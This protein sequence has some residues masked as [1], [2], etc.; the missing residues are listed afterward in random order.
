MKSV[1]ILLLFIL[2]LHASMFGYSFSDNTNE[3]VGHK[4][5]Y[6]VFSAS[7]SDI[8]SIIKHGDYAK[9][10]S[11]NNNIISVEKRVEDA[12]MSTK[13]RKKLQDNIKKYRVI[14]QSCIKA[15]ETNAP[16]LDKHYKTLI[17]SLNDF[18]RG[19]NS[20]GF[21]PLIKEWHKLSHI[22]K[23]YIK[24]PSNKLEKEFEETLNLVVLTVSEL[25]L[26]EELEE[27]LLSYLKNYQAYFNDLSRSYKSVKYENINHIKP[28]SYQ[29]K[30]QIKLSI[31]YNL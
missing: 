20:T 6:E 24:E 31:P 19:I 12:E 22:K 3:N 25:Y 21:T 8:N 29:I 13:E 11:F 15:M 14:C 27:P 17:N 10:T 18:D 28:L 4:T 1:S 9:H 7:T 5:I 23:Q 30:S 26:D 16:Q 2:H